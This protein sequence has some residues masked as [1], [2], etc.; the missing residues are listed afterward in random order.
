MTQ[1]NSLQPPYSLHIVPTFIPIRHFK[2]V[3]HNTSRI[4]AYL[5]Y[6]TRNVCFLH[7]TKQIPENFY[8]INDLLENKL[9]LFSATTPQCITTKMERGNAD[10]RGRRKNEEEHAHNCTN[11]RVRIIKQLNNDCSYLNYHPMCKG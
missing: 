11:E 9:K 1:K 5:F 7:L 2:T 8:Y 10:K 3:K 6:F 4:F